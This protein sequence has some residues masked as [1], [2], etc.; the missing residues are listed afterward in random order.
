[1]ITDEFVVIQ[2]DTFDLKNDAFISQ[3]LESS[4]RFTGMGYTVEMRRH[5]KFGYVALQCRR[6]IRV[7]RIAHASNINHLQPL[8]CRQP[9]WRVKQPF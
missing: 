8:L 6:L 3:M 9:A 1:M 2:L 4:R 7:Y 5:E